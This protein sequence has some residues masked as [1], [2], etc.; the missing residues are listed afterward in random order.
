MGS[1]RSPEGGE[2]TSAEAST[3]ESDSSESSG[4]EDTEKVGCRER[5]SMKVETVCK[6]KHLVILVCFG[7]LQGCVRPNIPYWQNTFFAQNH[8]GGDDCFATPESKACRMG[9]ADAALYEGW[10]GTAA[11]VLAI[12][13]AL[14]NGSHSD[15]VGRLPL[16]RING[17]LTLLPIIAL[18]MHVFAGM[19]L[20]LYLILQP[21]SDG[22]DANGV[23]L[24]VM[25][26]LITD[27]KERAA[28]Y[29]MF[30]VVLMT[31][32]GVVAPFS[33]FLPTHIAMLISVCAG[34]LKLVYMFAVFPETSQ[35]RPDLVKKAPAVPGFFSAV[36]PAFKVLTRNSFITRVAAV[37]I[38]AGLGG[39]GYHIIMTPWLTGYLGFKKEDMF[40]LFLGTIASVLLWFAVPLGCMVRHFGDVKVLCFSCLVAVVLPVACTLCTTQL[41]VIALATTLAG[42]AML[43]APVVTAIKSN[44]V[45]DSEQ[46]LIQGFVASI[47]KATMIVGYLLFSY[48]FRISS[49]GGQKTG[50]AAVRLPFFAIAAVN[51]VAFLVCSSLPARTPD[52]RE[53]DVAGGAGQVELA[54][55]AMQGDQ[56]SDGD[57]PAARTV[58]SAQAV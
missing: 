13:F 41:Q 5:A 44:L 19:T 2:Y 31:A 39:S 32:I 35:S 4:S 33:F 15:V 36:L 48:L 17:T 57:E 51:V 6:L 10:S 21:L 50:S 52:H 12:F 29:G 42:P 27:P 8:G 1:P 34:G 46:G 11:N 40:P 25:S 9:A 49:D 47:G 22:F 28:A 14:A 58:G 24:A 23:Y 53:V 55:A 18:A 37:L 54:A 56:M 3:D 30:I 43:F 26:D 20:W 7:S 38:L 16:I 45:E